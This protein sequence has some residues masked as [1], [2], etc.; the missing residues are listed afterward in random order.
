MT[1]KVY[2][3]TVHCSA[4]QYSAI[5]LLHDVCIP[6]LLGGPSSCVASQVVGVCV[7]AF[8]YVST[9]P[10]WA[11][12][13]RPGVSI[14][15]AVWIPSVVG[16]ALNILLGEPAAQPLSHSVPRAQA[17]RDHVWRVK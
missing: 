14:N 9:I 12:E 4:V 15:K 8:S 16:V 13:K 10:S 2:Y 5:L 3:G 17:P 7:F 1:K 11:N 6:V